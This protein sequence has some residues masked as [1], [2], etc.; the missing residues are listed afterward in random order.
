MITNNLREM[1]S[2]YEH[3]QIRLSKIYNER[4]QQVSDAIEEEAE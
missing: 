3:A 1:R 4:Y 2:M